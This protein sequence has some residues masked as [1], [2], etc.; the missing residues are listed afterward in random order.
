MPSH[1]YAD[2]LH[3][4]LNLARKTIKDCINQLVDEVA[5]DPDAEGLRRGAE[6]IRAYLLQAGAR[7]EDGLRENGIPLITNTDRGP[8][9]AAG[10]VGARGWRAAGSHVLTAHQ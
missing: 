1:W 3:S 7:I 6:R 10:G 8:S 5:H 9:S 4:L 2:N